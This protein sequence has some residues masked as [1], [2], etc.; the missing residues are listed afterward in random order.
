MGMIR[1]LALLPF[2][3]FVVTCGSSND[4]SDGGSG[5]ASTGGTGGAT[6]CS[7]GETRA[8]T[9]PGACQG[10]QSCLPSGTWSECDCGS[11]GGSGGSGGISGSGGIGGSSGL[12]GS[13]GEGGGPCVPKTCTTVGVELGG[14]ACGTVSDGCGVNSINCG[15]CDTT[16]NSQNACGGLPKPNSDASQDPA[17]ANRCE[18]GCTKIVNSPKIQ[19]GSTACSSLTGAPP[20]FT[21]LYLCSTD[22][23]TKAPEGA[24]LAYCQF[25]GEI[26]DAAQPAG[27]GTGLTRY[28]WCCQ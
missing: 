8:C 10:G 22:D 21:N 20:G 24:V 9:G 25:M 19:Y 16:S 18:G 17:T 3:V 2:L 5:G 13:G 1:H 27:F 6:T 28:R 4:G 7:A 14:Q 23:Q 12:A 26:V 15:A 11:T